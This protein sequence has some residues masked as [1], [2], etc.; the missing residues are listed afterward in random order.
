[1]RKFVEQWLAFFARKIVLKHRPI[2]I[3]ITGSVGKTSTRAA[4]FSVVSQKFSAYTPPKNLNDKIGLPLGIIGLDSP[5]RS[6]WGWGAVFVHAT[7]LW[8]FARRYPK[9][10]V[11]EYGIDRVGEMDELLAIAKPN[12]G[13]LTAIGLSHY[14]FFK[15]TETIEREKGRLIEAVQAVSGNAVVLNADNELTLRQRDK[16]QATVLTYG[17]REAAIRVN[18]IE[19]HLNDAAS[20][21]VSVTTPTRTI[22]ATLMAVGT[23]HVSSCLAA[24]A[25]AE[26][27]HIETDL[28]QKG[29]SHYRPAPSRLSVLSGL[30]RSVLIDD[31][32]NAAPDSMHEALVL[33]SR[34]PGAHKIAVLGDMLELGPLFEDAHQAVGVEVARIAPAHLV[35]VG[36]GGKIIAESALK[37]GFPEER[38]I[39]FDRSDDAQIPVQNIVREGSV[40][41]VKGSQGMRMEKIVKEVM[42]E[43]MRATE[44]VCR[45]YGK[46]LLG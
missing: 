14:E 43:P 25:V 45:Q 29:L 24:V 21:T 6:L 20:T 26:V 40:V 5:G 31:T 46:W 28:V 15:D 17:T 22:D 13:I 2:I 42:A 16:T 23:T 37:A 3:G 38:I 30:K 35:T 19:E 7:V 34:F 8:L 4:V 33:F 41:L 9:V 10:L 36:A 12:I 39:S 11:L 18:K 1:M 27:M 44:L 32:Y